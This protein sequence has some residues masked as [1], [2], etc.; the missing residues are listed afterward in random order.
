MLKNS[1][2]NINNLLRSDFKLSIY[3][4]LDNLVARKNKRREE[5][6]TA[7]I[8]PYFTGLIKAICIVL[9]NPSTCNIL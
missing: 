5:T 4:K 9:I 7:I 6:L 8:K 2:I 3:I 1:K